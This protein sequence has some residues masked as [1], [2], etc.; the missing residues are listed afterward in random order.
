MPIIIFIE[1]YKKIPYRL[2]DFFAPMPVSLQHTTLLF[3][4]IAFFILNVDNIF[5]KL[6][7]T[8]GQPEIRKKSV[9]SVEHFFENPQG[10]RQ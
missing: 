8:C 6:L 7:L 1:Y 4:N 9:H 3:W 10:Y 2:R 5:D